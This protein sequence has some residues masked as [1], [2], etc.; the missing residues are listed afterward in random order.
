MRTGVNS[1]PRQRVFYGF[2]L[3]SLWISGIFLAPLM[4]QK[5]A[6]IADFLYFLYKPAC[7][8]LPDR[9][10]MIDGAPLAVCGRCISFYIGGL[11]VF[12][13]YLIAGK[14]S[15]WPV[16]IYGALTCPVVLDFSLAKLGICRDIELIRILTGLLLG[17]ALFQV[18]ILSLSDFASLKFSL[19]TNNR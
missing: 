9:S 2:I 5:S 17:I 14:I 16:S 12:V 8:Q 13:F 3:L 7:H 19:N 6:I 15:I 1:L 10:F 18:L 4:S 11:F